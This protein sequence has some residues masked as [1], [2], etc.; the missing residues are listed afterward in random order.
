MKKSDIK[1]E[2]ILD[3]LAKNPGSSS[4]QVAQ[5]LGIHVVTAHTYLRELM[6]LQNIIREGNTRSTRYFLKTEYIFPFDIHEIEKKVRWQTGE[7]SILQNAKLDNVL[8]KYIL[9]HL[10]DGTFRSGFDGILNILTKERQGK[11]PS[12]DEYINGVCDFLFSLEDI[13]LMRRK[14]GFFDGT[15]SLKNIMKKYQKDVWINQLFFC[16]IFS[17]GTRWKLRTAIELRI[18]KETSNELYYEKSIMPSIIK[19]INYIRNNHDALIFTPPTRDRKLQFRDYFMQKLFEN[20]PSGEFPG[21]EIETEK[22]KESWRIILEQKS[23]RGIQRITN[24]DVSVNVKAPENLKTMKNI[25]IFDD[26][27]TTW[28][29]INAIALKL[30]A[31]NYEGKITAITITWNFSY[32]PGITDIEEV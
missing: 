19:I 31:Q 32:E 15:Q 13:E 26:S 8:E 20:Y 14:N 6:E 24:A 10:A 18:A 17:L 25:V 2:K 9:V 4:T 21:V 12:E 29:T 16:E 28:A 1:R 30:R 22:I 5:F 11:R 23:L 27:F 7:L 3:F